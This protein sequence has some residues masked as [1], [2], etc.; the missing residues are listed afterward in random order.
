MQAPERAVIQTSPITM[1]DAETVAQ[2]YVVPRESQLYRVSGTGKK[3][4]EQPVADA[5]NFFLPQPA[6]ALWCWCWAKQ[7]KIT[8]QSAQ[9]QVKPGGCE[10]VMM[11]P[12]KQKRASQHR[13]ISVP[14]RSISRDL[15]DVGI[16]G[17]P[18]QGSACYQQIRALRPRTQKYARRSC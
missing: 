15:K 2:S 6:I 18:L 3:L 5:S 4:V 8:C 11:M 16:G 1:R 9:E 7:S 17:R 14:R 10:N 13:G 12:P